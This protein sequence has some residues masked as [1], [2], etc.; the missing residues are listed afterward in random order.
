MKV[1]LVNLGQIVFGSWRERFVH[2]DTIIADGDNS[3]TVMLETDFVGTAG[4]PPTTRLCAVASNAR[5]CNLEGG[6]LA[7]A[8]IVPLDVPESGMQP[9]APAPSNDAD[10]PTI[11]AVVTA[12]IPRFVECSRNTPATIRKMRLTVSRAAQDFSAR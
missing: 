1:A 5:V 4:E 6:V 7:P 12:S 3:P 9:R 10:I 8:D 11:G 2:G